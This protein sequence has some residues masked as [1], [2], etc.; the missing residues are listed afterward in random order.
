[1]SDSTAPTP[2][3]LRL[4]GTVNVSGGG[5]PVTFA[6]DA[7]NNLSGVNNASIFFDRQIS[8]ISNGVTTTTSG[9]GFDIYQDSFSDGQSSWTQTLSPYSATGTY[10]VTQL[11]IVDNAGNSHWYTGVELAALGLTT[12]FTVTTEPVQTDATPPVVVGL[13]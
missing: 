10:N 11:Y 1:M 8:Y 5:Q 3:L 13:E 4:P 9:F 7:L 12:S 6:L 2:T